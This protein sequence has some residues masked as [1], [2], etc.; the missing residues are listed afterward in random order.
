MTGDFIRFLG[1]AGARFAMARQLRSSAGTHLSLRGRNILLD[2]GPGTLL[3][4]ARTDP[5]LDPRRLDA[6]ILSHGHIDHSGDVNAVLDAVTA[7]GRQPGGRLFAP[8]ECLEGSRSVVFSYLLE[9]LEE[10]VRL[11]ARTEYR[12]DPLRIL[13]SPAHSHAAETY[14]L[15]FKAEGMPTVGFVADTG[16]FEGLGEAY[17]PADILVVNVVLAEPFPDRE[18]MHLSLPEAAGVIS[19]ARPRKA[20]L[21]H[22]G[23]SMLRAGPEEKAAAMAEELGVEVVAARDD[24]VVPLE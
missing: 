12:L 7:G 6:V 23:V 4:C 17:A 10:V 8:A 5:P 22:F 2:P 18:I 9:G 21:T 14:G 20:V 1:T 11:E 24:M 19:R 13:T 3:R 15:L 16:Y